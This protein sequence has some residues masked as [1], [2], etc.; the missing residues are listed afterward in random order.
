MA[1][2]LTV[3]SP[4]LC[5]HLLCCCWLCMLCVYS[6]DRM[7]LKIFFAFFEEAKF[8]IL[9]VGRME[10]DRHQHAAP[11]CGSTKVVGKKLDRTCSLQVSIPFTYK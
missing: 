7:N 3:L 1:R 10:A 8:W 2:H 9:D 4:W 5:C 11:S 6:A